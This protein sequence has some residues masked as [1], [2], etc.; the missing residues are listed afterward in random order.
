MGQV[1]GLLGFIAIFGFGW[2][3]IGL[4][5]WTGMW[6][7]WDFIRVGRRFASRFAKPS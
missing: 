5:I 2:S 3:A 7:L 4:A 6:L 1:A